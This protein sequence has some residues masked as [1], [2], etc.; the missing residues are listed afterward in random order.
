MDVEVGM[1]VL[2]GAE[3]GIVVDVVGGEAPGEGVVG[4]RFHTL[5]SFAIY[6]PEY[7]SSEL[8]TSL[9]NVEPAGIGTK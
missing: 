2:V 4:V 9:I 8:N 6:G 7:H 5:K 1:G 3:V